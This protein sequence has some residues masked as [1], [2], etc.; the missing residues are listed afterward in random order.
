M[1]WKK[2]FGF[3][4]KRVVL[5]DDIAK[6]MGFSHDVLDIVKYVS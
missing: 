5:G 4:K 6:E 3:G 1:G 2:I